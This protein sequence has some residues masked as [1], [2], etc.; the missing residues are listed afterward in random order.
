M[1]LADD[2]FLCDGG[3]SFAAA[4]RGG[5]DMVKGQ[6]ERLARSP[7]RA[8]TRAAI[9]AL[10]QRACGCSWTHGVPGHDR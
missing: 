8:E 3:V 6:P 4:G 10:H 9:Q 7:F 1:M 2:P 5:V